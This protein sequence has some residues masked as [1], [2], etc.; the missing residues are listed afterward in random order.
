MYVSDSKNTTREPS[1]ALLLFLSM[2][3]SA[4]YIWR[5]CRDL[6]HAVERVKLHVCVWGLV[7]ELRDPSIEYPPNIL[8]IALTLI[9]RR[10]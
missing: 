7:L 9:A 1:W 3:I 10:R 8:K 5:M 6:G 4:M 2:L